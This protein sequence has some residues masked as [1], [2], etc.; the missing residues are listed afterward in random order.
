MINNK[1]KSNF[2]SNL[3]LKKKSF[4]SKKLTHSILNLKNI[5]NKK[6]KFKI[7][8]F[9]MEKS[10]NETRTIKTR[11]LVVVYTV[12][13]LFSASNTLLYITDAQGN[14]KVRY[15]AG[16]LDFKG[17]QKKNRVQVL[18]RFFKELNKL[19]I[20]ILKDKPIALHLS[21]VGSYRYLIVR[22]L[23]KLFFI[24]FLKSYQSFPYNG[25]RKKKRLR[26]K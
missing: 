6:K 12:C 16:L 10:T 14:L 13:F 23:K 11:G 18:N 20:S 25:C 24:R 5:L 22:N 9:Q 15:S 17:K 21:N 26:K 3:S 4:Y 7:F 19:K 1:E 8:S 2:Q